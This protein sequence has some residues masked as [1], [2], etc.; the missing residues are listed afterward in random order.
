MNR[1]SDFNIKVNT[2]TFIGDKI[3]VAKLFNVEI[4]VL[5]YKI[6]DSKKKE[7]TKCLTLQIEKDG[8][9]RIVFT[10]STT[11]IEQI[12]QVPSDKFPFTTKIVMGDNDRYEFT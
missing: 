7:D 4:S 9:K 11:L 3:P 1:F 8:V 6:E 10:G 12:K 2:S 5:N